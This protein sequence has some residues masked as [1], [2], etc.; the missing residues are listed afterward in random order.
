MMSKKK[1]LQVAQDIVSHESC[2]LIA[3]PFARCAVKL[4][5]L[6]LHSGCPLCQVDVKDLKGSS[7]KS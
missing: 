7:S 3:D 1:V 2:N 4:L 5:H 6:V